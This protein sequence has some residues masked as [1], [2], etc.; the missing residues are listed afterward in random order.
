MTDFL[1]SDDND[2]ILVSFNY[3]YKASDAI[4]EYD[5]FKS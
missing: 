3:F 1:L 5:S 2:S 4:F